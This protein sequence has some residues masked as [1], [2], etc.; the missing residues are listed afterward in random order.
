MGDIIVIFNDLITINRAAHVI[1]IANI[2]DKVFNKYI[3][4]V[5]K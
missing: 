5:S 1:K 3:I 2:L 4:L